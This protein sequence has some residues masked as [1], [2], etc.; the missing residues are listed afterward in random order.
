VQIQK[1]NATAKMK[2]GFGN[3]I[4]LMLVMVFEFEE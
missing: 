1:E 4:R 3:F 2:S